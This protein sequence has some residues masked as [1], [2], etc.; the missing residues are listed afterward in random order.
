MRIYTLTRFVWQ[1]SFQPGATFFVLFG[2]FASF[3]LKF[4]SLMTVRM[5]LVFSFFGYVLTY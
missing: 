3:V 1:T 5:C 4:L 2:L